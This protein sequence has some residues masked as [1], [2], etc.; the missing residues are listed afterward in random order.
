MQ[1][2]NL[3]HLTHAFGENV[4]TNVSLYVACT[5]KFSINCRRN[6]YLV[7]PRCSLEMSERLLQTSKMEVKT[8]IV[9][10]LLAG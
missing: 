7:A 5:T 3:L 1:P 6:I 4:T 10:L 9:R 8:T 2:Q